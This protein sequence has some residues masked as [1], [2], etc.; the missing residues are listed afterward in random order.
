M[1]ATN[2][3]LASERAAKREIEGL[4]EKLEDVMEELEERRR[5]AEELE[6]E[7][8]SSGGG[9]KGGKGGKEELEKLRKELGKEMGVLE[10][11]VRELEDGIKMKEGEVRRLEGEVERLRIGLGEREEELEGLRRGI[12][13]GK[14]K[15]RREVVDDESRKKEIETLQKEIESLQTRLSEAEELVSKASTTTT[16]SDNPP[17]A[18]AES[19][20]KIRALERDLARKERERA[21]IAL[22]LAENDKQLIS[23]LAETDQLLALKDAEISR[24]QERGATVVPLPPS[25]NASISGMHSVMDSSASAAEDLGKIQKLEEEVEE[26]KTREGELK[27]AM[28]KHEQTIEGLEKELGESYEQLERV[29]E[30]LRKERSEFLIFQGEQEVSD[31]CSILNL[32][33]WM[34]LT[35]GCGFGC[36]RFR[37]S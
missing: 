12:D 13:E 7:G 29:K 5:M 35:D 22:E 15:G 10:G 16:T 26:L 9:G 1:Q 20:I 30:E 3:A 36:D 34:C 18:I 24:L 21:N 17:P 14:T 37:P 8:S 32:V 27:K 4:K 31:G 2:Q 19:Q 23:K 11:K 6:L 28:R 33:I 25:R